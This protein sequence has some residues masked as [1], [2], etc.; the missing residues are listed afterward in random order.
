[1]EL[2]TKIK[3][4]IKRVYFLKVPVD[5]VDEESFNTYVK[6]LLQSNTHHQLTFLTMQGLFKARR[7]W[8]YYKCI[9]ESSLILP[10]SRGIRRGGR[11]LHLGDFTRY[12]PF[13]TI[14]NL[15]HL[16]EE[17]GYSVYL[18]GAQ[19]H[20]LEQ[21]ERNLRTSFPSL[22]IIGRFSGYF[23]PH[24]EEDVIL[25]IKK[26]HPAIILVGRGIKDREMW[27][28]RNKKRLNPGI[29]IWIDNVFEIFSGR[30]KYISAGVFNSGLEGMAGI[31]TK[32]WKFFRI[33]PY[34]YFNI[35]LLIYKIFKLG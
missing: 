29:S 19:K 13:D 7:R 6:Q 20:D 8:D 23:N 22:K 31:S 28:L 26:S 1:M 18:L 17:N 14:I 21:A 30:E 2:T 5:I 35:L 25:T 10:V 15:L 11:L 16:A 3:N 12:N 27:I 33:F 9:A 24:T 34:L 4:K 32:P